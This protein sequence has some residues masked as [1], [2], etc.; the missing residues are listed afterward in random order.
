MTD[1]CG[2][3]A[4]IYWSMIAFN[5][6]II[7]YKCLQTPARLRRNMKWIQTAVCVV[8]RDTLFQINDTDISVTTLAHF[9]LRLNSRIVRSLNSFSRVNSWILGSFRC[10]HEY[11]KHCLGVLVSVF[12]L[13][14][15]L[16]K[17]TPDSQGSFFTY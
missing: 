12:W 4:V 16:N 11:V 6:W 7:L 17:S 5:S 15:M 10:N 9:P 13:V 14:F 1:I 2:W 3:F 8:I